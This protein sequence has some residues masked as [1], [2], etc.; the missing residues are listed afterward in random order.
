[1]PWSRQ[2]QQDRPGGTAGIGCVA[3][4][5]EA[6]PATSATEARFSV[7]ASSRGAAC[8]WATLPLRESATQGQ[9]D[10]R[11]VPKGHQPPKLPCRAGQPRDPPPQLCLTRLPA[12]HIPSS[13]LNRSPKSTLSQSTLR[14]FRDF[15]KYFFPLAI[16]STPRVPQFANTPFG[17]RLSTLGLLRSSHPVEP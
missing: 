6:A 9:G 12:G 14:R 15:G 10:G 8:I 7:C 3:Q 17:N 16:T 4:K 5:Q 11:S 2:Q 1:M 13:S